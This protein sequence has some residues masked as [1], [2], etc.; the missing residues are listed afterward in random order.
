MNIRA[1]ILAMFAAVSLGATPAWADR[2]QGHGH[3]WGW[4]PAGFLLGSVL[5][6]EAFQPRVYYAPQIVYAPPAYAPVA[7]PY[8]VQGYASPEAVS[9]S[10]AQG[11]SVDAGAG[12]WYFCRNPSGYYPYVKQCNSGWEKISPVPP[13]A[14]R[15]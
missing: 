11:P 3:G 10:L 2:G 7:Q 13:G 14:N 9:P 8:Y 1:S 4:G 5:L 15:P 6:Y 12:W